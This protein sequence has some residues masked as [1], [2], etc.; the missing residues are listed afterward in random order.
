LFQASPV[1]A[2]L[3]KDEANIVTAMILSTKS[4]VASTQDQTVLIDLDLSILGDEPGPFKAYEAAIRVEYGFVPAHDYVIGR[5]KVLRAFQAR[6]AIYA[7]PLMAEFER[8]AKSNI[9]RSLA[10]LADRHNAG[11]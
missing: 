9:A 7:S 3:P 11:A 6:P 2:S 5:S 10:R 4:H 1:A 8:R